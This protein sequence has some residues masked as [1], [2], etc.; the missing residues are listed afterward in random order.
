M[1][2]QGQ[3]GEISPYVA[4]LLRLETIARD[5]GLGRWSKVSSSISSFL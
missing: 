1:K 2:E 5:Q 3:K 4:E